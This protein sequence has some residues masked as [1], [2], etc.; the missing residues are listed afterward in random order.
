MFLFSQDGT[1]GGTLVI[2]PVPESARP[3]IDRE[4]EVNVNDLPPDDEFFLDDEENLQDDVRTRGAR[5]G[6]RRGRRWIQRWD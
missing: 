5:G 3:H 2:R 1:V 4:A 6:R